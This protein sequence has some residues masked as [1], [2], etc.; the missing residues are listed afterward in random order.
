MLSY[1]SQLGDLSCRVGTKLIYVRNSAGSSINLVADDAIKRSYVPN[2]RIGDFRSGLDSWRKSSNFSRSEIAKE[3]AKIP[4]NSTLTNQIDLK[5]G[6]IVWVIADT[7]LI[8]KQTGVVGVCGTPTT[9]LAAKKYGI[10]LFY[11]DSMTLISH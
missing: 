4:P 3:L 11:A 8:P 2:L 7:N 10:F 9:N 5:N 6:E 1:P